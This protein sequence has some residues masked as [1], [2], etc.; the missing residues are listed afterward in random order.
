MASNG[1]S[2][3]FSNLGLQKILTSDTLIERW[4]KVSCLTS[5]RPVHRPGRRCRAIGTAAVQVTLP[6]RS[7]RDYP[8]PVP[9]DLHEEAARCRA[10]SSLKGSLAPR[11]DGPASRPPGARP[12]PPPARPAPA[13]PQARFARR[14]Y[15]TEGS[16][17]TLTSAGRPAA[18]A[19]SRAPRRSAGRSTNSAS[20]PSACATRS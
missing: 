3:I 17:R 7:Q 6:P 4:R 12:V 11:P 1:W 20:Q 13:G 8:L 14:G 10:A 2:E 9:R 15:A 16:V 18:N 19:R 5:P